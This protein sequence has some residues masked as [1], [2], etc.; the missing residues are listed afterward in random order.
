MKAPIRRLA[1]DVDKVIGP[2]GIESWTSPDSCT[3]EHV[4]RK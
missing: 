1:L 3:D 2:T 4:Q